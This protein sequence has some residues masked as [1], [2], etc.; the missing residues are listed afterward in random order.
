MKKFSS[1]FLIKEDYWAIWIGSFL[2]ILGLLIYFIIPQKNV[3]EKLK[4]LHAIEE[5]EVANPLKSFDALIA[6]D[7]INN[8]S[9][10]KTE[11]GKSIK[12]IL[13]HP[14]KWHIFEQNGM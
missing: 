12:H 13:L 7:E 1:V 4:E 11:I 8:V 10:A 9:S 5:R 6:H 3:K 14:Q 2:L